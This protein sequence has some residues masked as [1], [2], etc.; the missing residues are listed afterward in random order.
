MRKINFLKNS[1]YKKVVNILIILILFFLF[2]NFFNS[3]SF[4][5]KKSF[6]SH[7]ISFSIKIEASDFFS[8]VPPDH[9][10]YQA[11]VYLYEHGLIK[12]Y[13]DN[14]FRGDKPITRYEMA[15]LIYNMLME[16]KKET[17]LKSETGEFEQE[18]KQLIAKSVITEEEAKLIKDLVAE[19]KEELLDINKRVI[20]LEKR[21]EKIENNRLPLYISIISLFF[22]ALA[23]ALVL[24]K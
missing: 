7:N 6:L 11:I 23:L 18:I 9:W 4:F 8:D 5:I 10:A 20:Y 17:N 21:V 1:I 15:F 24:M 12:G 2:N 19:F 14:T 16:L 22:S 3:G 13:S